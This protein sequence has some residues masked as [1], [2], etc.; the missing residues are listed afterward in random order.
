MCAVSLASRTVTIVTAATPMISRLRQEWRPGDVLLFEDETIIRFL[1][2]RKS[3]ELR[4]RRTDSGAEHGGFVET[5]RC[6]RSRHYRIIFQKRAPGV[7][8][9]T[10]VV[11]DKDGRDRLRGFDL[12]ARVDPLRNAPAYRG[13]ADLDLQLHHFKK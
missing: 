12:G 10:A 7:Y 3:R 1:P 4:S 5:R 2:E 8:H 9:N 6:A 11:L 13:A